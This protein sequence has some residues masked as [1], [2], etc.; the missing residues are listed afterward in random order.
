MRDSWL[1]APDDLL[2]RDC[3]M[4]FHKASGNGGQKVNKTSSAV[5]LTHLPSGITVRSAE[6]RSQHENRRHALALLRMKMALTLREEPDGSFRIG[7]PPVSMRNEAY[8]L[9]IARLLDVFVCRGCDPKS[10]AEELGVSTTKLIKLLYRDPTVWTGAQTL[11]TQREL[12]PLRAP[13]RS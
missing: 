3:R 4:D 13:E 11:R 9:F 2:L 1:A 8:P 7:N 6:S 5:R 12:P 10:S